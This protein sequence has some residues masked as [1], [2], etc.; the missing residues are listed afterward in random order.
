MKSKV[1]SLRGAGLLEVVV[2]S[3]LLALVFTGLFGVLQL[4]TRLATDN[5]SRTGALSLALER[6]E[7]IRS[8]DYSNIGTTGGV[9]SGPLAANE[10]IALNG[11]DYV[12]RTYIV[13]IDDPK[14]GLGGGDTNG[15]T[16]DY[17]RV[18]VE[19]SWEGQTG[20]RFSS[21]VSDFMPLGIEQ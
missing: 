15:I 1:R 18:K 17:K 3:A 4:G 16:T 14:D 5:K 20:T 6:I 8:L 13:Y 12:R 9:P 2:A 21:L 11:V 19:V 7:Y 10:S